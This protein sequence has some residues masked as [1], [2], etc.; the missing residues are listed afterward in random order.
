M[1]SRVNKE[2]MKRYFF[3]Y[4]I[5][6]MWSV[7]LLYKVGLNHGILNDWIPYCKLLFTPCSG[8]H[9]VIPCCFQDISL[10]FNDSHLLSALTNSVCAVPQ[11]SILGP[12]SVAIAPL[13]ERPNCARQYNFLTGRDLALSDNSFGSPI[14]EEGDGRHHLLANM[15][16]ELYE[17]GRDIWP[18]GNRKSGRTG[19]ERAILLWESI[20]EF[21]F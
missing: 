13:S 19:D 9:D 17:I 10:D 16:A 21:N 5:F 12:K 20:W 11:G 8:L 6:L 18:Y 15:I 14:R 3:A 2:F 7:F 1:Q 4:L